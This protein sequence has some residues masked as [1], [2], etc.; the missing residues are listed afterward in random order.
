MRIVGRRREAPLSY[1]ASGE[2]LAQ[3]ARFNEELS[4]LPTGKT[5]LM[6]KG[7]YRFHT[8]EEAA[9]HAQK[10]LIEGMAKIAARRA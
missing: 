6:P 5:A 9:A 7:L 1:S 2:L 4:G 3:G 10:H 8:H